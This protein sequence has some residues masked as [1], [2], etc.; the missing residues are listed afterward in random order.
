MLIF[1]N[2]KRFFVV[3][4]PTFEGGGGGTYIEPAVV[5]VVRGDICPVDH[6]LSETSTR[7]GALVFPPTVT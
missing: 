4:K 3:S 1:Q 7:D 5:R 6:R 2:G